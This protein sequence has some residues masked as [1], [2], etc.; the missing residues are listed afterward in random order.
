MITTTPRQLLLPGQAAA[1]DGPVDMNIMYVMHHGFR[2]DLADFV[3][4]ARCTPVGDRRTWRALEKRWTLF[5]RVLHHHHSGEDAVVWPALLERAN[6]AERVTLEAMEEEHAQ[7]DPLLTACAE[8]FRRLAGAA[9]DD[10]RA[11]LVVRLSATRERLGEHLAHEESEAIALLQRVM[12]QREWEAVDETLKDELTLRRIVELV[13]WAL[14][15]LPA[16]ARDWCF[17]QPGGSGYRL[18]GAL[19]RHGFARAQRRAFRHV[20]GAPV[21]R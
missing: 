16:E 2:R 20:A 14:H 3:V 5:A 7:I 6:P 1:P 13:P 10:A 12:T 4:A 8:G 17:S 19:T 18:V 21:T 11:A 9:D 15:R